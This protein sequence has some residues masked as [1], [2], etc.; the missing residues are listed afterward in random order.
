MVVIQG[1][2]GDS[3]SSSGADANSTTTTS[4]SPSVL[5]LS[6]LSG[7]VKEGGRGAEKEKDKDGSHNC[8]ACLVNREKEA[9]SREASWEKLPPRKL[10]KF[11]ADINQQGTITIPLEEVR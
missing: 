4:F 10:E 5:S 11:L 6:S 9:S 2:G 1:G 8:E 7:A 3:A